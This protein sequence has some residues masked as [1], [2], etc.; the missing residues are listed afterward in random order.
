[1]APIFCIAF[2]LINCPRGSTNNYP[3]HNGSPNWWRFMI[4]HDDPSP[5]VSSR[6]VSDRASSST[7]LWTWCHY[8][9]TRKIVKLLSPVYLCCHN[10]SQTVPPFG[11]LLRMGCI[12]EMYVVHTSSMYNN[13][14][15]TAAILKILNK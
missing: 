5:F 11:D 3:I 15:S 8:F 4:D 14:L 7:L 6:Y 2:F 1:M 10:S 9:R 12:L 13:T